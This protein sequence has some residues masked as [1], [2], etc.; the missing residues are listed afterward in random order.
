M[1]KR[2]FVT[3][4]GNSL[5]INFEKRQYHRRKHARDFRLQPIERKWNWRK[6]A[7]DPMYTAQSMKAASDAFHAGVEYADIAK[8]MR[9]GLRNLYSQVSRLRRT[10]RGMFNWNKRL[11]SLAHR[12][13][14]TGRIC[15]RLHTCGPCPR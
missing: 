12:G 13:H 3:I 5:V 11:L 14:A 1:A 7:Y 9:V 8:H 15:P 4:E 2:A 10:K 6:R